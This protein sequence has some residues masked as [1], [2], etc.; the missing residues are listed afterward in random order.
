ILCQDRFSDDIRRTTVERLA[1]SV[2]G[3]LVLLRLIEQDALSDDLK[4]RAIAKA[5]SHADSNIRV[6]YEKF[7]PPEKRAKRLGDSVAAADILKLEGD[8]L[9]GREIFEKS[10]AAQCKSCHAVQ[11]F[12]GALGPELTK[13][14]T[15]Y[16]RGALLETIIDPSKAI[17]PEFIP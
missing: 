7:L 2:G 3:A 6:L 14:G 1:T 8:S 10:T 17:A 9:R 13:I 15:K 4:Q 16:E 11:G 12:G 5:T